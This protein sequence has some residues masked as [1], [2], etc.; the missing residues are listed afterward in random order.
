MASDREAWATFFSAMLDAGVLLPPSPF[1]AWFPGMAHG[2]EE[3][4]A[5]IAAAER[6]LAA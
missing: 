5:I 6:A 4:D 2:D 1:E 3:I